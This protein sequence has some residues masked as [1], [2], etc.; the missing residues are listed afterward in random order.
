MRAL[1]LIFLSFLLSTSLFAQS[2]TIAKRGKKYIYTGGH[3]L[4]H[5][6][7]DSIRTFSC[8]RAAVLKKGK[9]G[10]I[11]SAGN[12]TVKPEYT[13]VSDFHGGMASVTSQDSY[14]LWM[15]IDVDGATSP[16]GFDT[17]YFTDS[18]A[19]ACRAWAQRTNDT[20][21][22][23]WRYPLYEAYTSIDSIA[24]KQDVLLLIYDTY[25]MRTKPYSFIATEQLITRNGVEIT[26]EFV[27]RDSVLL[28]DVVVTETIN[29]TQAVLRADGLVSPWYKSIGRL[30]SQYYAIANDWQ[31]GAMNSD[32]KICI[33]MQYSKITRSGSNFMVLDQGELFLFDTAG[34]RLTDGYYEINYVGNGQYK[35]KKNYH[36]QSLQLLNE[37]G[38][39][40]GSYG[41]V[42]AARDGMT[43]VVNSD[44]TKYAYLDANGNQVTPWY[45]RGKTWIIEE[46]DGGSG[47]FDIIGD[48]FFG[49]VRS[50]VF[51]GT[52]G[53]SEMVGMFDGVSSSGSYPETPPHHQFPGY[54]NQYYYYYGSDFYNGLAYVSVKRKTPSPNTHSE[55]PIFVGAIDTAGRTVLPCEYYS[56]QQKDSFFIVEKKT[57]IGILDA[58]G[59]IILKPIYKMITP[60][61]NNYFEVESVSNWDSYGCALYR[62]TGNTGTFLTPSKYY[63]IDNAGEGMFRVQRDAFTNG[64]LN[65]S[66][67]LVIPIRFSSA[68]HF[69]DGRAKVQDDAFSEAYYID[70]K[71]NRIR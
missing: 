1:F 10:F 26:P 11:D 47:L 13:A 6:R 66:G 51:V 34:K 54:D 21:F 68:G 37:R 69:E 43:R 4:F 65:E 61:G 55:Q 46:E 19:I 67:K 70:V 3:K 9:W 38:V 16:A 5:T 53:M 50:L 23:I 33:P 57:G 59:N 63:N 64:Y 44:F 22:S 48:L 28:R 27:Y 7:Y 2:N 42:Y 14:N 17:V 18:L 45:D 39:I 20:A 71:G 41:Y 30:D 32:F 35:A 8:N 25:R 36:D 58:K 15:L 60:L 56:I 31:I 62:I 24:R 49:F 29:Q 12:K 52:L 40:T